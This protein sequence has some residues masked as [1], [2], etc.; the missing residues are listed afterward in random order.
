LSIAAF[1]IYSRIKSVETTES[2]SDIVVSRFVPSKST[3]LSQSYD[4][5][6]QLV[7]NE[8]MPKLDDLIKIAQECGVKKVVRIGES[9]SVRLFFVNGDQ[10]NVH[11]P[12]KLMSQIM[13]AVS[14]TSAL[15]AHSEEPLVLKHDSPSHLLKLFKLHTALLNFGCEPK[16][17]IN[18]AP[19]V[20]EVDQ[21]VD[22]IAEEK[23]T[24]EKD[25]TWYQ[26]AHKFLAQ[27]LN[28]ISKTCSGLY[29][30]LREKISQMMETMKTMFSS[31]AT[32][33]R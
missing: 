22:H 30:G 18:T 31:S 25:S 33:S 1:K 15:L 9:L 24:G 19:T 21:L 26:S 17:I 20:K 8:K 29:K 4:A 10:M 6:Y 14:N 12:K 5:S 7:S 3:A 23:R 13:P 16:V 32:P 27:V 28:S 2:P 11:V